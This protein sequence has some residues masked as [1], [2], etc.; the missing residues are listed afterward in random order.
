MG[1]PDLY[2]PFPAYNDI[3]M[4]NP[5]A[6]KKSRLARKIRDKRKHIIIVEAVESERL[7]GASIDEEATPAFTKVHRK[8]LN[9]R[10]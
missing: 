4:K 1:L 8:S 7:S 2:R 6:F 5:E 9:F 3:S 10:E